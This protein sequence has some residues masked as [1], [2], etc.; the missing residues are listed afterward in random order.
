MGS[1]WDTDTAGCPHT[2]LP[3][4]SMSLLLLSLV[5]LTSA[6]PSPGMLVWNCKGCPNA[7]ERTFA[8]RLCQSGG[9]DPQCDLSSVSEL[10]GDQDSGK[11][12][13]ADTERGWIRGRHRGEGDPVLRH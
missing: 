4:C 3:A 7:M 5:P 2:S 11:S 12:E 8:G 6:L 13:E 1:D 9:T 10:N